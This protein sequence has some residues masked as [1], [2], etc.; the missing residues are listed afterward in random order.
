M[1]R[2]VTEDETSDPLPVA[3]FAPLEDITLT[4][5]SWGGVGASQC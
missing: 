1:T 2:G 4:D 3:C 5:H